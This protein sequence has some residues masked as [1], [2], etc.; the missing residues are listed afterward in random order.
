MKNNILEKMS[1]NEVVWGIS[2]SFPAPGIV[3]CMYHDWDY[4]WIDGQHG[5]HTYDSVINSVRAAGAVG[6]DTMIRVKNHDIGDICRYADMA[7]QAIMVPMVNNVE[8]AVAVAN[9]IRYAPAGTRSFG[10]RRIIDISSREGALEYKT[11]VVAQIETLEAI[12][13]VDAIAAVDGVDVLFFGPDDIKTRL[14]LNLLTQVNENDLLL[15][16]F[17]KVAQAAK[18]YGKF[19]GTVSGSRE[20]LQLA[21][22]N[23]YNM[24]VAGG[25]SGFI[26]SGSAA[27]R[28]NIKSWFGK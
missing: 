20:T 3:E 12:E 15:Q 22:D 19:A 10:G 11:L 25:E 28:Q 26:K 24:L 2:M 9:A 13:N 6:I 16:G 21:I 4:I 7:P 17:V 27:A 1:K 18:K 8:Q 14:G 23:G 5:Q